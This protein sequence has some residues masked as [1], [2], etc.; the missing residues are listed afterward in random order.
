MSSKRIDKDPWIK[1]SVLAH[2]KSEIIDLTKYL[3]WKPS[4]A[5]TMGLLLC[6]W[7]RGVRILEASGIFSVGMVMHTCAVECYEG[8]F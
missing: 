3:Q 8:A 7:I 4:I 2:S 6:V 5:D 1:F